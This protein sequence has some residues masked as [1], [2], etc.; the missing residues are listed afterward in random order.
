MWHGAI[1]YYVVHHVNKKL[2]I[3][4]R[5]STPPLV[6]K[7]SKHGQRAPD[8]TVLSVPMT[9]KLR[10]QL[11][12]LAK[13]DGRKAA[14]FIR[15]HLE[16]VARLKKPAPTE[17]HPDI[18]SKKPHQAPPPNPRLAGPGFEEGLRPAPPCVN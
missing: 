13:A 18:S 8:Q 2:T 11:A 17:Q 6:K 12:A 4:V 10:A 16:E 5:C 14:Q 15:L 9:K 7:V 1:K 3:F